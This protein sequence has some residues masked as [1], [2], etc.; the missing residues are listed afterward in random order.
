[1]II[2]NTSGVYIMQTSNQLIK[3]GKANDVEKRRRELQ[4]T[5]NLFATD[6]VITLQILAYYP[7]PDEIAAFAM[8]AHLQ[9][10]FRDY[11][12]PKSSSR[13]VF[14]IEAGRVLEIASTWH[15]AYCAAINTLNKHWLEQESSLDE[16]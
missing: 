7:L 15:S 4:Q 1:M 5:A 11:L 9:E 6:A 14:Q 13:E 12:A 2:P 8:E 16:F 3:I 10:V